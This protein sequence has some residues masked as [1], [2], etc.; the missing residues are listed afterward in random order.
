MFHCDNGAGGGRRPH[1]LGRVARRERGGGGK[2]QG[3]GG[4]ADAARCGTG[5]RGTWG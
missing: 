3:L 5:V 2:S 4:G 1:T